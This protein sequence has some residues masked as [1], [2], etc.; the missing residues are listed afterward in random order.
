MYC[1]VVLGSM[2]VLVTN[3]Y[4]C[5]DTSPQSTEFAEN[6][7]NFNG[8]IQ[9]DFFSRACQQMFLEYFLPQ[10]PEHK[11]I[12]CFGCNMF[13]S[14]HLDLPEGRIPVG[15]KICWHMYHIA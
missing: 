8:F 12:F 6:H 14:L 15:C 9:A 5:L 1:G 10:L 3:T 13:L 7:H 11:Y 2:L 4:Q